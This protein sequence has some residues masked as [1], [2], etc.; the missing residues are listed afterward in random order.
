[1]GV[2]LAILGVGLVSCLQIFSSS[3]RLQD[4]STRRSRCILQARAA[5]DAL[6]YV[7]ELT[8]HTEERPTAEGCLTRILVRHAGAEE[9]LSEQDL[10]LQSDM[11]LRY[12]QVDVTWQDGTGAKSYTLRSLRAAPEDA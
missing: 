2:A 9:G 10:D 4:S 12:L 7:P 5:M 6:L 1:V 11:S 3:L 8:D